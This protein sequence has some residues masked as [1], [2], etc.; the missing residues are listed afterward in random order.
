LVTLAE[1]VPPPV[2]A[3]CEAEGVGVEPVEPE[4]DE[5]ELDDP[6]ELFELELAPEEEFEPVPV[7]PEF[8]EEPA[9][10]FEVPLPVSVLVP[11]LVLPGL[12]DSLPA[13]V[14]PRV[15]GAAKVPFEVAVAD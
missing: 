14:P 11:V 7:E 3:D 5:P 6:A 13:L 1:L 8:A 2:L 4:L 10:P 12:I 15:A 9:G